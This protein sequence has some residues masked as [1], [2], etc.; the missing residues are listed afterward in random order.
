VVNDEFT[1]GKLQGKRR[2]SRGSQQEHENVIGVFFSNR[3]GKGGFSCSV[4]TGVIYEV[5]PISFGIIGP[6]KIN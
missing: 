6:C 4:K 5:D 1:E 3:D 2:V